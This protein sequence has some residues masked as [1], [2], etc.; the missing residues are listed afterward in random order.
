MPQSWAADHKYSLQPLKEWDSG[1]HN[2]SSTKPPTH[3]N[4]KA[5]LLQSEACTLSSVKKNPWTWGFPCDHA[6]RH[7]P[8]ALCDQQWSIRPAAQP[9]SWAVKNIWEH[10]YDA[11][12][13]HGR[14]P[15][16][17]KV[18]RQ[19]RTR[20]GHAALWGL[21]AGDSSNTWKHTVFKD[22]FYI[23]L[24]FQDRNVFLRKWKVW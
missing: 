5:N 19:W 2:V 20:P 6:M 24:S 23:C 17:P 11:G 13:S 4:A 1:I 8:A 9:G 18:I 22:T 21:A 7:S 14:S 12:A 16:P 15:W 3:N 10:G